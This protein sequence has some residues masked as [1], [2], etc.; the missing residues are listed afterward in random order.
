MGLL[1]AARD[2]ERVGRVQ[3]DG[4]L[5]GHGVRGGAAAPRVAQQQRHARRQRH[6]LQRAAAARLRAVRVLSDLLRGP[7][8]VRLRIRVRVR[9]CTTPAGTRRR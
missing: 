3:R 4:G 9:L 2:G 8:L 7:H 1:G 6:Q 5:R